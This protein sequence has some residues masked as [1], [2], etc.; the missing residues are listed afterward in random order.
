MASK[1]HLRRRSCGKKRP[2]DSFEQ[3]STFLSNQKGVHGF[4][5][6]KCDFCHK[7]HFGHMKSKNIHAMIEKRGF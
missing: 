4:Q 5:I 2:F 6:Y 3:A 1:R 7:W